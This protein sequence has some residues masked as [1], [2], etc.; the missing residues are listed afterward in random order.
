MTDETAHVKDPRVFL[1]DGAS[2]AGK[3]SLGLAVARARRDTV[4]IL[5]YTT[6]PRR[7]ESDEQEYIFVDQTEFDRQAAAGAFIEYRHYEFG[8]SYGL[9]ADA[10][11]DALGNGK[12]ALAIINLGNVA[13]AKMS[14]PAAVTILIDVPVS[15]IRRRLLDRGIHRAD[16]VAERLK[17]AA[18]VAELRPCYDY[19]VDNSGSLESAVMAIDKIIDRS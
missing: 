19:I 13:V 5:R 15:V 8:M 14:L 9:P 4:L 17:N 6:R 1:L 3:T 11:K 10:V 2:G 16:Q 7:V 18:M 12:H